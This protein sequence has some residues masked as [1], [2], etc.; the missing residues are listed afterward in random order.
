MI[1]TEEKVNKP[2]YI[3]YKKI[4]RLNG[5]RAMKSESFGK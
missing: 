5:K 2:I 4:I 3:K 1:K